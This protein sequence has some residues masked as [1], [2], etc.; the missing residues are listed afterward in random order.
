MLFHCDSSATDVSQMQEEEETRV[1]FFSGAEFR[2]P[3]LAFLKAPFISQQ[4]TMW[5]QVSEAMVVFVQLVHY[6]YSSTVERFVL[7][8]GLSL[9]LS[10]L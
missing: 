3:L 8:V 5:A 2:D 6:V 9:L 7:F 4:C 10:I 1:S